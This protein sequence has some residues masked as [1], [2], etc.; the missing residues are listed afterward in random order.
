MKLIFTL[1][2]ILL[3]HQGLFAGDNEEFRATWVITW[4]HIRSDWS[5]EKNKAQVREI[6]DNHKK[7]NMNAILWQSRQSGTAY[8]NSSYE[9][10]GYYAGYRYP[11]YDPLAY[12]I[13][14]AH[15][16]G[17]ELHAWFN[18][19]QTSSTYPGA[20][21]AEH[22]EWICR[23][24]DGNP[25]TSSRSVSPGL[26]AVREYT[27]N[28]AMEIVRNYDIDGLH[29]D[30]V[31]WNE[32]S[33]SEQSKKFAKLVEENRLLDGMITEAQIKDLIENKSGRYLYDVEHPYSAGVP[34][35]FG[36]WEDWWRWSVTDFVRVLHDSIQAV[37]PWVRLSAAALGKYKEGSSG[38]WNGY[39]VVFQDAALWFNE[40]YADQLTPMHYHWT[41]ASGFYNEL[42]TDWEPWILEGIA[43]GRLYTVGP[44]SYQ[45]A[46]N[47]VWEKHPEVIE[48]CRSVEWVDGFQFFSY[49][50]W[51]DYQY[52]EE[53][54]KTF[55]DR[56]TKIRDTKLIESRP[57]Y[58]PTASLSKIDSLTYEIT[59]TPPITVITDHWYAIYRSTDDIV[60]VDNDEI[61]DIHF[62]DS[63]FTCI[64]NF[65]GTQDYNGT[66]F[67][68]ATVLDRYWNESDVSN[69]SQSD[70]IPSFPPTVVLTV[71]AE[72]DTISIDS[73]IVIYFSK[74]MDVNS[75]NTAISITPTI[76]IARLT[77]SD[78]NK[79]L[80]IETCGYFQYNTEYTLT[81]EPSA[82]DINGKPLDGNGDGVG[83][84]AFVLNFRAKAIDDIPPKIFFSY[85]D[86]TGTDTLDVRDIITFVFNELI[87]FNTLDTNSIMLYRS[88][89]K[90]PIKFLPSTINNK[91]ALNIQPEQP[92]EPNTEYTAL[93]WNTIT[94]TAGNPMESYITANF[95]TSPEWYT[96]IKIIEDFSAPGDWK[97]PNYSGST[98]GIIVPNTVWGYTSTIYL[99]T[100]IPRKT[101][102]LQYEWD[103]TASE[104]L[105]REYLGGGLPRSIL[106]DTTYILQCY[107]F[108]D[109]SN[110]K[111]RFCLDDST[112]DQAPFHEVSKW[113]TLDWYGWRLI[114]W[115]L[116]DPNSVGEWIGDGILH[117]PSLRFDSF[118]LTH[119]N[120]GAVSGKIYF[121]NL[122][123]VKKSSA[124]SVAEERKIPITV[125]L[126]QN[127]PNPFNS[128]TM[129]TF[130]LSKNGFV[131]LKVYDIAG[132]E[133]KTLI[134]ES[135][136]GGSH[137]VTFDATDLVA[138]VYYYRLNFDKQL[139]TKKMLIV[140]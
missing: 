3:F 36:S 43:D 30:Y 21:A 16:R 124:T 80:T 133:V 57:Q 126:F 111:F 49:R 110:N 39:Y 46:E 47:N 136:I 5:A 37:K 97:Q 77:W 73:S 23:D 74:T 68:A 87:D 27:I 58:P 7:A 41:T 84:D 59:V 51:N 60:D 86:T 96:E 18:V 67:Y 122:Q 132:R 63:I 2:L 109:G 123:L 79:T 69:I 29:L 53:A 70:S 10:W 22:P 34:E 25:M 48:A 32:Y 6:L 121:D 64:D 14:E 127:Y 83:G 131:E 19:F 81:I 140:R 82:K 134:S 28:V 120:T 26:V 105:L 52:W 13:E 35:G 95:R 114:E 139:T 42:K 75:L 9:P 76:N 89:I 54:E 45:F 99:P 129:I 112:K 78:G 137:N 65:D 1:F 71:P 40:G 93:L 15:K 108:G 72:G 119:D 56:K 92:L 94:D 117:G 102:Y 128:K 130:A 115:N 20:P 101:A 38:G 4:E 106:F 98:Q 62:G 11:G 104:F 24:R 85:P 61:V 116:S 91:T 8:Y 55:F 31:R 66:Y 103:T 138:G 50:W 107:I 135:M 118:Q 113:I 88:C 17:L 125:A 33:S 12:A 90:I 100:T 44:G